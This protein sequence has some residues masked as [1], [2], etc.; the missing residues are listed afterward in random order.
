MEILNWNGSVYST[1][2]ST[3]NVRDQITSTKQYQGP[4]STGLYQEITKSHDGYGR[5]VTKKDPIQT[6]ATVITYTVDGQPKT[7]TDARGFTQTFTYNDRE[8]PI[9]VSYSGGRYLTTVTFTYDGAGNRISMTDGTGSRK[10]EYDQLS[11]L[12][13]ETRQFSGLNGSFAFS[14]EYNLA[15]ALKSFTDHTGSHVEYGHNTA[16]A[17]ATVNGRGYETR[18]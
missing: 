16:G 8:L 6:T 15:G 5:L 14:Y 2:I 3:Y 17:L 11:Q 13:S 12:T 10:Y 9:A 7:I 18:L 1:R 4:E